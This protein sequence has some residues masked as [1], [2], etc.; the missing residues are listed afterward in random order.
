MSQETEPLGTGTSL[1]ALSLSS[2]LQLALWLL[3]KMCL[4]LMDSPFLF[5]T[6]ILCASFLLLNCSSF[7]KITERKEQLW[8]EETLPHIT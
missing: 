3:P 1:L 6:V 8:F 7:T 5:L 2:I 4:E